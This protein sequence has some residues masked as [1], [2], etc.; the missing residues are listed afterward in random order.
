MDGNL[1]TFTD[2]SFGP[3]TMWIWNFG[4]D[5]GST[6]Q[7]PTHKYTASGKYVVSLT[8]YDSDG[9]SST[10]KTEIELKL[11]PDFPI[12]RNPGGWNVFVTDDLTLSMSAVGLLVGGA[13]MYVS[14]MF[15]PYFPVITPKGRKV[16]G[17]LMVIA[18]L[19]FL[20]FIDTSWMKF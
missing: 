9:H 2:K 15:L 20:I 18:G 13:I 3:V 11:G 8:V 19:Y 12:E 5:T 7:N 17:G 14:A 16:I 4:D 6:K 1:L 10:A